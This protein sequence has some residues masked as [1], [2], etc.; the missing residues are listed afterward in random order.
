MDK[1]IINTNED[2]IKSINRTIRLKPEQFEKIMEISDNTGVSFN[3]IIV[4]CI[5]FA[6]ERLEDQNKD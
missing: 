2:K 3:K 4:Q 6:L 5:D 1:F